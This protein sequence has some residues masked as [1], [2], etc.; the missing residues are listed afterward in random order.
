MADV[1]FRVYGVA[2]AVAEGLP[3]NEN[4]VGISGSSSQSGV[5]HAAG[6]NRSRVVR[7]FADAAC[8]V[9]W[10]ANPTVLSD[11]TEGMPLGSEN[12]EYIQV[13]ADHVIA[14]IQRV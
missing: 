8:F 1:Y 5:M 10:G 3:V 12:P 7:L 2:G 6:G 11:G 9:T 14:V 13:Q 4:K